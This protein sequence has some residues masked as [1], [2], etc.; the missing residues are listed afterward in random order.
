MKHIPKRLIVP[1]FLPQAGCPHR[2][3]FCS[4]ESL[5]GCTGV[6]SP[7]EA[8]RELSG[9]L[10]P[11]TPDATIAFYGGSFTSLGQDELKEYLHV[12]ARFAEKG[13]A[14]GIRISTRPDTVD[15]R[16]A[17]LL[18]GLR[19]TEVE[20]GVQSM[21]DAVLKACARGHTARDTA[22]AVE[23]LKRAGMEVGVQMMAGLPGDTPEGFL[24]SVREVIS[25]GPD[26]ARVFPTVV[27][28]GAPLAGMWRAGGYEPISLDEAVSLCADAL[29]LFDEAGV[30]V[31]R[32]GLQATKSLDETYLAGPYHPSF[33]H[34]VKSE[35]AL[36]RMIRVLENGRGLP[37]A[38]FRVNPR[39]LSVYKGISGN[40]LVRL[41]DYLG[42]EDVVITQ[43][44]RLEPGELRLA[45][46]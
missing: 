29:E 14:S 5:T 36:R 45:A 16:L 34:M 20:L 44:P 7:E 11:G 41:K 27:V 15:S 24:G 12:A 39:E 42:G 1:V 33:G 46:L 13:M 4:Q 37:G 43:D 2:C 18:A 32:F 22:V 21:D 6:P 23:T 38:Q 3:I 19:V 40:N 8:G 10:G 17:D 26:F 25:L 31:I 9:H 30:P 28:E 35:R